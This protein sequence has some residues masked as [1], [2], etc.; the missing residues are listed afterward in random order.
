[1]AKGARQNGA[2][3][4]ERVKVTGIAKRGRRVTGVDWI[5]DD[6]RAHL[7]TVLEGL[8]DSDHVYRQEMGTTELTMDDHL[9]SLEY[10]EE[11]ADGDLERGIIERCDNLHADGIQR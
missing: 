5:S 9:R 2:V 1:M 8:S 3:V 10:I 11:L 6:A 7:F 4:K